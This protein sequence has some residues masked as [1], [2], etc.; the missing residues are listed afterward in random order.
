[1][2]AITYL[3]VFLTGVALMVPAF[4]QQASAERIV[5]APDTT[6]YPTVVEQGDVLVI[7]RGATAE[8]WIENH[9]IIVNRGTV[10]GTLTNH[11]TGLVFNAQGGVFGMTVENSGYFE[12]VGEY[13]SP[14]HGTFVN[15][16]T[17]LVQNYGYFDAHTLNVEN[18]G[19]FYNMAQGTFFIFNGVTFHSTGT[20][21]NAGQFYLSKTTDFV[22]EDG[23]FENSGSLYVGGYGTG[24]GSTFANDADSIVRNTGT[25]TNY[26]YFQNAG[27]F[28]NDG[29]LYNRQIGFISPLFEN[30]GTLDNNQGAVVH[31][32][33]DSE[34]SDPV[35]IRNHGTVNN[36][37][38]VIN[39]GPDA[40][41]TNECGAVFN[42]EGTVEG[43]PVVDNCESVQPASL[44]D[45]LTMWQKDMVITIG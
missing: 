33:D 9:G 15:L 36:Y 40:E 13:S 3:G 19:N 12:N 35:A 38:T 41:I 2:S 5:I 30:T 23:V 28:E 4:A 44:L 39:E 24:S 26:D 7:E 10:Y 42:D 6:E 25:V 32:L 27:A 17:G 1:M 34:R 11:Q 20:V 14:Q 16:L 29:T 18:H 37:S 45:S 43:N 21:N 8:M 31:N 22:N